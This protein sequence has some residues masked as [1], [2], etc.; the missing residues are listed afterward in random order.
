MSKI[1][2]DFESLKYNLYEI[3]NIP[4]DSTENKIKKAFIKLVK[5]FHPDK[6]S[7]LE[8]DIYHHIILSNQILLNK[9]S[10][11]KYDAYLEEKIETFNELKTKFNKNDISVKVDKNE[12]NNKIT[13]LNNKHGYNVALNNDS[14]ID[15]FNNIKIIRN[16]E[17]IIEKEKIDNID[18][19]NNKFS[20][21]KEEG[22]FK[23]QIIEYNK[24]TELSTFDNTSY[25][26]LHNLETLYMDGP[27]VSNNYA[28]LDKAFVLEKLPTKVNTTNIDEYKSLTKKFYTK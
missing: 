3:L 26:N 21:Y 12:F 13:K 4:S 20:N 23:N 28:S 18:D 17:S 6:N 19:F 10:R 14:T 9:D 22:K 5:T 2:I 25:V 16:K 11:M 8:E 15:K 1:E 24:N 27:V 7:E